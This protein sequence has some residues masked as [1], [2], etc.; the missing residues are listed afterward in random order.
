MVE[1]ARTVSLRGLDIDCDIAGTGRDIL[2]LPGGSW[3]AQEREFIARLARLGRVITPE[4]PGFGARAAPLHFDC[5][6]DLAYVCLDLV[7]ALELKDIL[8]VGAN[9]GGWVAAEIATKTCADISTLMLIDP[10]GL[11]TGGR[12]E[13]E[14][15]DLFALADPELKRL[16]WADASR[17]D[18]NPRNQPEPELA[19]RVR[20]REALARYGWEIGRAHV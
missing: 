14:I 16:A 13:R 1:T 12:E 10:Y 11:R 3:L 17:F 15:A 19:R 18:E 20:A 6:D 5:A 2:Y 9:F 7:E 8:L 4:L